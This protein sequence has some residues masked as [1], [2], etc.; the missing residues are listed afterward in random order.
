MTEDE[1]GQE[2]KSPQD[3][4]LDSLEERL[5]RAQAREADRTGQ[6]PKADANEQMGQKV[7]SY[8]IGGLLGGA[9]IGWVL[10]KAF[11]TGHLLLIVGL[12]LGTIGGFWSIIKMANRR[13]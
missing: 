3:A 13:P 9:L 1:P 5:E 12:V 7:L 4:R 2:P 6:A 10:D 11:D 8:L